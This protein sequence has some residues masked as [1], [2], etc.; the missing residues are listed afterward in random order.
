[1]NAGTFC[2]PLRFLSAGNLLYDNELRSR[3]DVRRHPRIDATLTRWGDLQPSGDYLVAGDVT[4]RGVTVAV[5]HALSVTARDATTLVLAGTRKFDIRDFG[6][7]PPK[8]LFLR[9]E[10]IVE[11]SV[12]ITAR[13]LGG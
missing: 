11:V 3:I 1:V 5:E 13:R 4:F 12:V 10:P 8:V 2:V 9:V 6:M 7:A